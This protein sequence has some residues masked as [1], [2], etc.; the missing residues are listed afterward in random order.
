QEFAIGA[1]A[2]GGEAAAAPLAGAIKDTKMSATL[3][4]KAIASALTLGKSARTAVPALTETA[5]NPKAGGNEGR[6]LQIDAINA[7]GRLATKQDTT[8]KSVLED[9]TKGAKVNNQVK[10][11][12]TRA[13]KAIQERN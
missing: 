8:T 13:L 5:K 7:L 1:L 2:D 4:S 10:G 6:Q 3:R 9:I 11:A 12:A